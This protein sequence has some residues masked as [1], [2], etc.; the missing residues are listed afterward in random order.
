MISRTKSLE[1][2]HDVLPVTVSLKIPALLR[3]IDTFCTRRSGCKLA[4]G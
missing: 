2:G 1:M 3:P 4:K